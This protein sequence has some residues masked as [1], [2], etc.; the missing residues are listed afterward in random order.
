[1]NFSV[2]FKQIQDASFPADYWVTILMNECVLNPNGM[3]EF[4]SQF[5]E[6]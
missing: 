3:S 2:R 6:G 5:Y 4:S 1:M